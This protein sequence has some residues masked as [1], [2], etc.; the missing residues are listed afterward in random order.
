MYACTYVWYI[1]NT[2]F[3]FCSQ[4]SI[5][6]NLS[7]HNRFMRIQNEGNGKSS[8]WILN[9]DAKSEKTKR[10][11]RSSSLDSDAGGPKIKTNKRGRKATKRNEVDERPQ[12]PSSKCRGSIAPKSPITGEP[13]VILEDSPFPFPL[14][15]YRH[16]SSSN[17]STVSSIGR[18]SPIPSHE[19]EDSPEMAMSPAQEH[20]KTTPTP[21][22]DE[23]IENMKENLNMTI[24]QPPVELIA[25]FRRTCSNGDAS[26]MA[27]IQS[28]N[29]DSPS[30][31]V[32]TR[33]QTT[34]NGYYPTPTL[35]QTVFTHAKVPPQQQQSVYSN[36]QRIIHRN[37]IYQRRNTSPVNQYNNMPERTVG[38]KLYS[39]R[40][41]PTYSQTM[42]LNNCVVE[43]KVPQVTSRVSFPSSHRS[44][45]VSMVHDSGVPLINVDM[46]DR[47]PVDTD[48]D[49]LEGDIQCD[50]ENVLQSELAF[51]DGCLDFNL[52]NYVPAIT[53]PEMPPL[54]GYVSGSMVH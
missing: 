23:L 9:H 2:N 48:I 28:M 51:N 24:G 6:H 18:L 22:T 16:R 29:I 13:S 30:S 43:P 46:A 39:S 44:S 26:N 42:I 31:F 4:N 3:R 15:D 35:K 14:A 10:R 49:F 54:H 21:M 34:T 52:D 36:E 11:N 40:P 5:R 50:V 53:L 17:T 32:D 37:G 8:W 20:G 47:L 12:S 1:C 38:Q 7:L 45:N 25:P 19:E 27:P 33:Y 41:P